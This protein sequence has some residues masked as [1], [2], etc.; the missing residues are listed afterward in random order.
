MV[1][2]FEKDSVPSLPLR[3]TI[4]GEVEFQKENRRKY[5]M[6]DVH[7]SGDTR[8][9]GRKDKDDT[10]SLLSRLKCKNTAKEVHQMHTPWLE[11]GN[12]KIYQKR[13]ASC[14][15]GK[16]G[17]Q[18]D[19]AKEIVSFVQHSTPTTANTNAATKKETKGYFRSVLF[20]RKRHPSNTDQNASVSGTN[21]SPAKHNESSL[22]PEYQIDS[23]DSPIVERKQVAEGDR[24]NIEINNK[25]VDDT[26]LPASTHSKHSRSSNGTDSFLDG[27]KYPPWTPM[28]EYS[29]KTTK[30]RNHSNRSNKISSSSCKNKKKTP[31][32]IHHTN[33]ILSE[34]VFDNIDQYSE[35]STGFSKEK[36]RL[37][38]QETQI[39]TPRR[40]NIQ[41]SSVSM[42]RKQTDYNKF[43]V[44]LQ[45]QVSDSHRHLTT[46]YD[47]EL[48]MGL[49][50][51]RQLDRLAFECGGT[52]DAASGRLSSG[53]RAKALRVDK[54][55]FSILPSAMSC[56][57]PT[58]QLDEVETRTD[59]VYKTR[60]K[61]DRDS[62]CSVTSSALFLDLKDDDPMWQEY[63]D[64]EARHQSL[65]A[66]NTHN[67]DHTMNNSRNQSLETKDH[68]QVAA[69]LMNYGE[70]NNNRTPYEE[71]SGQTPKSIHVSFEKNRSFSRRLSIEENPSRHSY[72]RPN[73]KASSFRNDNFPKKKG[74]DNAV[75]KE[76]ILSS[77]SEKQPMNRYEALMNYPKKSRH[78]DEDHIPSKEELLNQMRHAVKKASAQLKSRK[79]FEGNAQD[80][81]R[82]M[83]ME[84]E[85]S[86]E[87]SNAPHHFQANTRQPKR[88]LQERTRDGFDHGSLTSPT[89]EID[90]Y[91]F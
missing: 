4:S 23:G 86:D 43:P 37:R 9:T 54:K 83:T 32:H 36:S 13:Y 80:R 60:G 51:H 11:D 39:T 17:K 58:S 64:N 65:N 34:D 20:G 45:Q 41:S 40:R 28:G 84:T 89:I 44:G 71:E 35:H 5:F 88:H 57:N 38:Y 24:Y 75:G 19:N 79:S 8:P 1:V 72:P 59:D 3:R 53:T 30:H 29:A 33:Q 31:I 42:L 26:N 78:D 87:S 81:Y 90:K 49:E 91:H 46:N 12:E 47:K 15:N 62:L 6:D 63:F 10:G 7:L 82:T 22:H 55:N 52:G 56:L 18:K 77:G 76:F 68:N 48:L 67:T 16:K 21:S 74:R 14:I 61:N 85:F 2:P 25:K 70:S 66:E 69:Q 73:S 27:R 50:M